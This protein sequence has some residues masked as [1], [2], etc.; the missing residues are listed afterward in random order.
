MEGVVHRPGINTLSWHGHPA[1]NINLMPL[2]VAL[3]LPI[4]NMQIFYSHELSG[5]HTV[6]VVTEAI[7]IAVTSETCYPLCQEHSP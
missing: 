3:F 4:L 5:G 1:G 7:F 6:Y 2:S